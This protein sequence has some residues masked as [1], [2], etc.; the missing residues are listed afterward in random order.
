MRGSTKVEIPKIKGLSK[1]AAGFVL[2]AQKNYSRDQLVNIGKLFS[3][4]IGIIDRVD[5]IIIIIIIIIII[6]IIIIIIILL[7]ALW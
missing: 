5:T 1:K 3:I 2:E 4:I 6:V 7:L